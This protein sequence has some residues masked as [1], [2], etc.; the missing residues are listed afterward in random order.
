MTEEKN[1]LKSIVNS[2]RLY[3]FAVESTK[4]II[5]MLHFNKY[6]T[7]QRKSDI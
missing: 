5:N 1:M 2:K 4:T 6:A 7:L 3:I